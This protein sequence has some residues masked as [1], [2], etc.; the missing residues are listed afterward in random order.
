MFATSPVKGN[1]ANSFYKSLTEITGQRPGWNSHKYLISKEC[2][3]L[4]FDKNVEPDSEELTS[5][6]LKLL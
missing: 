2:V 5:Q 1:K 3:V 4:S 6:I